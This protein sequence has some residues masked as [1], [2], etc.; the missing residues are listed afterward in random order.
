MPSRQIQFSKLAPQSTAISVDRLLNFQRAEIVS[1]F[2]R[3]LKFGKKHGPRG[4][5]VA[6][7]TVEEVFDVYFSQF[8]GQVN[9][10]SQLDD[11][12]GDS[13]RMRGKEIHSP[14]DCIFPSGECSHNEVVRIIPP[15][16]IKWCSRT[17]T[18][19]FS[20]KIQEVHADGSSR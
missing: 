2:C 13:W 16:K 10:L 19:S 8:G 17:S 20:F 14:E 11:L 5:R 9:D 6:I 7:R 3:R 4:F 1:Q 12:F 18:I 15:M